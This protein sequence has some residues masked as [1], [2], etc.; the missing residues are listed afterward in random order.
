M[1]LETFQALVKEFG[2]RIRVPDLEAD[3]EG[4]VALTFDDLTLHLQHDSDEDE[5]AAF[6]RLGEIDDL[7][8]L[9]AA[10]VGDVLERLRLAED[11]ADRDHQDVE[12]RTLDLARVARVRERLQAV[13]QALDHPG[14][15]PRCSREDDHTGDQPSTRADLMR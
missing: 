1:S 9:A 13:D 15:P 14:H 6:S 7:R 2:D 3:A 4:Y 5:A 10:V 11:G 8:A 12:E